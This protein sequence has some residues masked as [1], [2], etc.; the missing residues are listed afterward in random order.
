MIEIRF[1][2]G[3]GDRD[4]LRVV[5]INPKRTWMRFVA[6]LRAS[7]FSK[8]PSTIYSRGGEDGALYAHLVRQEI[9]S[10]AM[11]PDTF[12]QEGFDIIVERRGF[13]QRE[14]Q[15]ILDALDWFGYRFS[16]KV[17]TSKCKL[18]PSEAS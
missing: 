15:S 4:K 7:L 14:A 12:D 10:W 6:R 16:V 8:G 3:S 1:E 11:W 2:L 13:T 17:D 9:E 18:L 5:T